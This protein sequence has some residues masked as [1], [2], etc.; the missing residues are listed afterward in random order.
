VSHKQRLFNAAARERLPSINGV[1]SLFFYLYNT[2]YDS[3]LSVSLSD[4]VCSIDQH[5]RIVYTSTGYLVS[6]TPKTNAIHTGSSIFKSSGSYS[7]YSLSESSVLST[8]SNVAVLVLIC[9]AMS[10]VQKNYRHTSSVLPV[11]LFN[12]IHIYKYSFVDPSKAFLYLPVFVLTSSV[13]I[14][15]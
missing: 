5:T 1:L 13:Y 2:E 12:L 6:C 8:F 9:I 15:V 10:D 11:P 4:T 7:E 14:V 3:Q